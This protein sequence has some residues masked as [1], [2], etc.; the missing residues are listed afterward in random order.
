MDR[1]P[2]WDAR[3]IVRWRYR[4]P[5]G[6][7]GESGGNF[8]NCVTSLFANQKNYGLFAPMLVNFNLQSTQLLT[9]GQQ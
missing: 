7:R 9:D 5:Y 4:S 8:A 2:V 3:H 6:E 1:G